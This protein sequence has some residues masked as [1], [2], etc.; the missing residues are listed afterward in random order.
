MR[1]PRKLHLVVCVSKHPYKL[2]CLIFQIPV[3]I[4][5]VLL[6]NQLRLELSSSKDWVYG[7]ACA[8]GGGGADIH[9]FLQIFIQS[10]FLNWLN[11]GRIWAQ[12]GVFP[13][14]SHAADFKLPA[15][16]LRAVMETL[17]KQWPNKLWA[18]ITHFLWLT[19]ALWITKAPKQE[20]LYTS[21]YSAVLTSFIFNTWRHIISSITTRWA[22]LQR[23]GFYSQRMF[24]FSSSLIVSQIIMDSENV[25]FNGKFMNLSDIPF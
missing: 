7:S 18:D 19:N 25:V 13:H 1:P 20:P 21:D 12:V 17:T 6:H 24:F 4:N 2:V 16:Q 15:R 8:S 9:G 10:T 5:K 14:H 22:I 11:K 3:I 23:A